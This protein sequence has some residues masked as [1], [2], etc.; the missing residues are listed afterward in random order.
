MSLRAMEFYSGVGGMHYA[1]LQSGGGAHVIAAVDINSNTNAVYQH[2]FPAS[3]HLSRNICGMTEKELDGHRPDVFL[4][5]PPCQPFTRQGNRRDNLDHRTDSFFHLMEIFSKM[6]RPPRFIFLENVKGFESSHTRDHFVEILKRLGYVFQEFLLSPAQF[7]VPNSRLRYFLLAKRRPLKF[8][9]TFNGDQPI[10]DAEQLMRITSELKSKAEKP[11]PITPLG[12][13]PDS[14]TPIPI[15]GPTPDSETPIPIHQKQATEPISAY[16][17][18]VENDAYLLP[19]KT[20]LKYAKAMDIVSPGSTHSCCFTKAYGNYALGTGSVLQTA[21][22]EVELEKAFQDF[23]ALQK[24]GEEGL[25]VERLQSVKLRYFTPRE[26]A[27]LMSFPPSFSFPPSLS[28]AQRY[29]VMGNS[30]NVAVVSRLLRYLLH[31]Q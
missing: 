6:G 20:L 19:D 8:S 1:L 4:M 11:I 29:K 24:T 5:S 28:R 2:N 31:E 17:E 27:S 23:A 14:E 26:V 21:G 22:G 18:S 10:T 16:L 30:L 15:P 7:S 9:L 12:P 25:A 13:T 3:T